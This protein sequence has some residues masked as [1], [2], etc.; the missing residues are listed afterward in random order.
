IDETFPV[1]PSNPCNTDSIWD[2]VYGAI[3]QNQPFPIA[4]DEAIEVMR[5]IS[6]VRQGTAFELPTRT[7]SVNLQPVPNLARNDR[8]IA[9]LKKTVGKSQPDVASAAR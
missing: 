1:A 4:L 5:V 8:R 6:M 7:D 9:P 3:R 2:L